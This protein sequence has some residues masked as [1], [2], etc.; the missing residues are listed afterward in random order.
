MSAITALEWCARGAG[1]LSMVQALEF[2]VLT[3][4]T[5]ERGVWRWTDVRTAFPLRLGDRL[6][7]LLSAKGFRALNWLR[8]ALAVSV[9]VVPT[10]PALVFLLLI[11]LLTLWRWL[12]TF[13]GGSDHVA[14][15]LLWTLPLGLALGESGARVLCGFVALQIVSSYVLAGWAKIRQPEWRNGKAPRAFVTAAAYEQNQFTLHFGANRSLGVIAGW[16]VM[17][18]ELTFPLALISARGCL[19][20]LTAGVVFHLFNGY[21]FGLNRF[22]WAWLAA[23]PA[24]FYCAHH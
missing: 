8:L 16:T 4:L 11:H 7:P 10:W 6:S 21:V 24:L 13:N 3:E 2:L 5:S 15:L 18:F 23:Y 12:G 1:A 22:F 17:L 20:Y 19:A 14:L 9:L